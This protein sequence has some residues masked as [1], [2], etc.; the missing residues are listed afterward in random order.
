MTINKCVC[1]KCGHKITASQWTMKS[2]FRI[3]FGSQYDMNKLDLDLCPTCFDYFIDWLRPQCEV[4]PIVEE[5][6]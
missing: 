3:G 4:D 6:V 5:D 1:N 2:N